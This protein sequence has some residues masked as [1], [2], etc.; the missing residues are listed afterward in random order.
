MRCLF[1]L[2]LT[3]L[4][5]ES[6]VGA[7]APQ[8]KMWKPSSCESLCAE[9]LQAIRA[10]PENLVMRLEDAL[11]INES[12]VAEI[13]TAAMHAVQAE[14]S[15]VNRI[16]ETALKVAP[17]RAATISQAIANYNPA[18]ISPPEEIRPAWIPNGSSFMLQ[19]EIR[20]A[21]LPTGAAAP[22]VVEEVRRAVMPVIPRPI[23]LSTP[24]VEKK[25][26]RPP[27]MWRR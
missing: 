27:S 4:A 5:L 3:F 15:Q 21:E 23:V 13:V 9:L 24:Q 12:C 19:V 6:G 17:R 7:Q 20:R 16:M 11:V 8:A 2:V 25:R 14:P 22:P 10:Q 18:E 26:P 1:L